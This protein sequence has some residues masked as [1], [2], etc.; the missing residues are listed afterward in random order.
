MK[1][2]NG[3]NVNTGVFDLFERAY[4]EMLRRACS[5]RLPGAEKNA[6]L[7]ASP[8]TGRT[9]QAAGAYTELDAVWADVGA[10]IFGEDAITLHKDTGHACISLDDLKLDDLVDVVSI[11]VSRLKSHE[12]QVALPVPLCL[13]PW[14]PG[15]ARQYKEASYQKL[16]SHMGNLPEN[17][18]SMAALHKWPWCKA[19][20][21]VIDNQEIQ[22]TELKD[23]L[24]DSVYLQL[25]VLL[26]IQALKTTFWLSKET[27][28]RELNII[29]PDAA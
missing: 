28:A 16:Q 20:S 24:L 10:I 8:D 13:D 29:L 17:Y 22:L 14:F 4:L 3:I 15:T 18:V 19:E 21:V 27:F 25:F 2:L 6:L 5:L 7:I 11:L 23:S 1:T 12:P 26:Y 9:L